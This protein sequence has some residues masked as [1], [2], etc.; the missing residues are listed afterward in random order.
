MNATLK[1]SA[2]S[3]STSDF[4]VADL[5]LADFGRSEPEFTWER[6]DRAAA[7]ADEAK[8]TRAA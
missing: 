1:P 8:G 3:T 2:T 4:K 7:L 5:G 6:T